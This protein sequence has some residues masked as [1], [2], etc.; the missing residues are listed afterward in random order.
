MR[1][2][3]VKLPSAVRMALATF[4]WA[5]GVAW[6][7][8]PA[9]FLAVIGLALARSTVAAG[10]ALAV[11]G[12]LNGVV[13]QLK[14][15]HGQLAPLV[16]WLVTGLAFALLDALTPPASSYVQRRFGQTVDLQLTTR[17][18]THASN[19][20]PTQLE[21][22]DQRVLLDR[23]RDGTAGRMTKLVLDHIVVGTE[24]VQGMLLAA[25]LIHVEPVALLLAVP[26][27]VLYFVAEWRATRQHEIEAPSRSIKQRWTRYF[28]SLLLGE[29]AAN[30][31]R[32]LGLAPTLIERYRSITD[33][34]D[35]DDRTRARRHLATSTAFGALTTL[36]FYGCLALVASRAVTG[37]L[38]VGDVGVFAAVSARLRATLSRLVLALSR[39]LETVAAAEAVRR[40]LAIPSS[41][42]PA[43]LSTAGVSRAGV[44]I[45]SVWFTYPGAAQP[46]LCGVTLSLRR[47]EIVALTGPNGAGK[48][49][50]LKLVAGLYQPDRGRILID[51]QDLRECPFEMHRERLA[52]VS[53]ES[54]R[55]EATA[56]DNIAFGHWATL[57][58]ASEA[59]EHVAERS[60]VAELLRG[61][62]RGYQT[63]LGRLF[64][65]HDLSSGQ[66]QQV[67]LARAQAR[68]AWLWLLDEPSAHMDERAERELLERL[69]EL[70]KGRAIL[71]VSHRPRPLALADRVIV[72]ER[73]R[74]VEE[75]G[76]RRE[77]APRI[78][79]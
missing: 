35:A 30:E 77:S 51:G 71:L 66:W 65:E 6:A 56:R 13:A 36:I 62:P 22:P 28:S 15:G 11:R 60:G 9:L 54:L 32:L 8:A 44:E 64:G 37:Q 20:S 33:Q 29:R 4:G 79:R 52:S 73:G 34:L 57:A 74:V 31:V 58:T 70:G 23:A 39:V 16:P 18:M 76:A 14:T 17:V 48:T 38:T 61:L 25:V 21:R 24:L 59:V 53:Q 50:L 27:A 67:A 43:P 10:L 55:F 46:A 78:G 5:L 69:R 68:P 49:T 2:E 72:L 40:F 45:E 63:I 47:G 42:L 7:A 3:H 41:R 19:L 1:A 75:G 26:A 12:I